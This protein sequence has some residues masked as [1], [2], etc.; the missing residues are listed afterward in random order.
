MRTLQVFVEGGPHDFAA[1]HRATVAT[2]V[3]H[4]SGAGD[5]AAVAFLLDVAAARGG[6]AVAKGLDRTVRCG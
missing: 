2:T 3:M 5:V 1:R 4:A 6:A